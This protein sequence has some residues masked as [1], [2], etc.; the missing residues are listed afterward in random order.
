M[1]SGVG[2]ISSL[3]IVF[4]EVRGGEEQLEGDFA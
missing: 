3:G 4:G 1:V 2:F